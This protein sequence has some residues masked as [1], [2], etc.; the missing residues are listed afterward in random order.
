MI[1]LVIVTPDTMY[2]GP[3]GVK[4]P[5]VLFLVNIQILIFIG[6]FEFHKAIFLSAIQFK[7]SQTV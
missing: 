2:D 1:E 5:I 6:F 4:L 7:T 3:R